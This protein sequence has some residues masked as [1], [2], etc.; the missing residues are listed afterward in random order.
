MG[1]RRQGP[2]EGSAGQGG[3]SLGSRVRGAEEGAASGQGVEASSLGTPTVVK[4]DQKGGFHATSQLP[5]RGG[6]NH[7]GSVHGV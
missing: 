2:P 5:V 1:P 3:V 6:P 7:E 4:M